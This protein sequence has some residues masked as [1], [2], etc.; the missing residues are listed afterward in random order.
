VS[1]FNCI[2]IFSKEATILEIS[3]MQIGTD[4][5]G[6]GDNNNNNNNNII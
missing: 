5:G 2:E 4:D 6:G 1:K 3:L